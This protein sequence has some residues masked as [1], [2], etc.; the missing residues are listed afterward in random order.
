MN[1][2]TASTSGGSRNS[3]Q[4]LL[5]YCVIFTISWVYTLITTSDLANWCTENILTVLFIGVMAWG[6]PR[7]RFSDMS[8]TFMFV[9]LM[10][11]ILG[12][13]H[14]YAEAPIG[15]A[16]RDMFQLERNP[17]D[18]IVH[19]SF[20]LLMAYPM[21]DYFINKMEWPT[22]V[23]WVLPVEITL[24]FSGMYEIIEYGVAD[25]FFPDVGI[26][27]LG[28]Q[29]DVWDAQKD[30]ILAFTGAIVCMVATAAARRF[31]PTSTAR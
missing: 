9:F 30:M 5:V 18:R 6:Y 16:I 8:F 21:R 10:L 27:Y 25:I 20:G 4:L 17:Y 12:A 11:H 13:Q 31:R 26:A 29:G 14:T 28:T 22:W 23:C 3:R 2:T 24:S 1:F 15:Y 7:F 19:F